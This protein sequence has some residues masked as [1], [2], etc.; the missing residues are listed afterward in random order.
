MSRII[1]MLI[2]FCIP[3]YL[4]AADLPNLPTADEGRDLIPR[5]ATGNSVSD[6]SGALEQRPSRYG[7]QPPPEV[8]TRQESLTFYPCSQCHKYWKTNP[9]PHELAPVHRVGL[10]HGQDRFWCLTC[11]DD[12]D[13]DLLRTERDGKVG[14]DESWR[15]CGQCHANRQKDWYFGAHGKRVNDWQEAPV[16]YN[17]THC[18]DP[19]FPPFGQKKPQPKPPVRAGLEPMK[20]HVSHNSTVWE[21]HAV[22]NTEVQG[23]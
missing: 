2:L 3:P 7:D 22:K 8:P 20:R 9:V 1:G 19:H 23:D 12:E 16:R 5:A 6:P 11:H 15:V 4:L 21:R 10:N 17:C 18:H 14:F 13:R